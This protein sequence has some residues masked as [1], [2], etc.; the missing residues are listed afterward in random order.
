M[1]EVRLQDWKSFEEI[2]R[3]LFDQLNDSRVTARSGV[4]EPLFR[5]Q[6]LASWHLTTTL[7][8]FVKDEVPVEGYYRT[9][10]AVKPTIE[11]FT[12][13]TWNVPSKF[14]MG[15]TAISL[16][17]SVEFMAYLRHHGFPSPLLD[18]TLSPYVA[19]FFAFRSQALEDKDVAIYSFLEDIGR[20]KSV[21]DPGP[22]I[23]GIGRYMTT[24][25]RHH[26]QQCEYT[27]C[28]KGP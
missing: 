12:D 15:H 5:G 6:Q 20:G 14:E 7:E 1:G 2:I 3:A 26:T 9:I 25:K 11:S 24:Q 27:I 28:T 16:P 19:A 22:R 13:K 4:S 17:P 21:K 23:T 10:R 8:R 18:W